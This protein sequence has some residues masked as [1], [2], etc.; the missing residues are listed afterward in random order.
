MKSVETIIDDVLRRE[1][2]YVNH[3]AD[4]GGATNRGITQRTYS[5]WRSRHGLGYRDVKEMPDDDARDIY[6]EEYWDAAKC[7]Q[8]PAAVREIHFD[9]AVNHGVSRA[10]RLLQEA[11]RIKA[12]GVIGPVTLT[13]AHK[14]NPDTLAALYAVARYR[15]YGSIVNRD[16]SQL[17]FMAGW[18][19]RMEEFS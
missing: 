4:R 6:R 5:T 2:G 1:G 11:L 8:L 17:V 18:M 10:A 12:D 7:A 3:P 9:A 13:E 16:R 15:F 19:R 14:M